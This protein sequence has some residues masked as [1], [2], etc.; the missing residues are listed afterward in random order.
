MPF[1]ITNWKHAERNTEIEKSINYGFMRFGD[2]S[3]VNNPLK[4]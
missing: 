1:T 4:Q 2:S 3:A